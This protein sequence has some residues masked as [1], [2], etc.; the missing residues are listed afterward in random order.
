M[1]DLSFFLSWISVLKIDPFGTL[2]YYF[3]YTKTLKD[4]N[5]QT[6]NSKN[7]V[8]KVSFKKTEKGLLRN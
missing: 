5:Q 2:E 6:D 7:F 8:K 4:Y 3:M 1:H